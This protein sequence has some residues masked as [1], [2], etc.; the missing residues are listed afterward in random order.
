MKCID[1]T[2]DPMENAPPISQ[3]RAGRPLDAVMRVARSRAVYEA[4]VA[5]NTDMMTSQ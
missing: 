2:P 5:T 4:S 1:Q 3:K